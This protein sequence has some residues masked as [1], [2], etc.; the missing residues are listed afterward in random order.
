VGAEW[1]WQETPYSQTHDGHIRAGARLVAE[2]KREEDGERIVATRRLL[3][4]CVALLE[5]DRG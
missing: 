3:A 1:S 5:G 4:E 2:V